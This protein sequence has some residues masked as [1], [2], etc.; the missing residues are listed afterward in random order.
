MMTKTLPHLLFAA[1]LLSCNNEKKDGQQAAADSTA[2]HVQNEAPV[3]LS[4]LPPSVIFR[5]WEPGDP[6]N[7][8][9]IL[10]AYKLWD[11]GSIGNVAPY[12]ADTVRFD[13]PDARR[14]T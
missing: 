11:S 5:N 6:K 8:Q 13:L 14:I 12:F 7:S 9:L 3:R 2:G 10:H 4:D 1:V